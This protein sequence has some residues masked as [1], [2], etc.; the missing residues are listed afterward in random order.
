MNL[1][2]SGYEPDEL[3]GCSTPRYIFPVITLIIKI[4]KIED[5]TAE[6][7]EIVLHL[8]SGVSPDQTVDA[9]YAFTSCE[10]SISPLSCVIENDR[11]LFS[12]IPELLKISTENTTRLL[13]AELEINLH[14]QE[15]LWHFASLEKIFIQHK[16]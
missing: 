13:K 2:P 5:N 16:I 6:K 9:L 15:E 4:K 11:P 3:P 14:E 7:V 8:V 10:I 12:G 1:R